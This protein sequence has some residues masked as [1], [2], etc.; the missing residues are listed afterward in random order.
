MFERVK[1]FL[2]AL[3]LLLALFFLFASSH[4]VLWRGNPLSSLALEVV[5]PIERLLAVAAFRVE[6]LWR[7]Y[8]YLVNLRQENEALH[9]LLDRQERKIIELVEFKVAHD[10]LTSLLGLQEAYPHLI[11]KPAHVLARDPVPWARSVIISLGALDGVLIDQ[12]VIQNRGVVGRVIETAPH[13]ARVLLATDFTSSIDAF[14]QR[15]RAV[16]LLRGGGSGP[17]LLKYV[18]KDEDVCSGDQI[19]TSGLDGF[20]PRGLALGTVSWV[21]RQSV[22]MFME[23]EAYPQVTF[24]RLEEVMV[25]INLG[26]PIDWLTLAPRFRSL[27]EDARIW[28][29]PPPIQP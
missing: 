23:V 28:D 10:R 9:E 20:F 24:D 13:Y 4:D 1:W 17:L 21:N 12:A 26:P 3:T 14:V 16:G 22:G 11:M 29:V 5:G 18:R 8:L 19:I 15:S 2:P 27:L 25:L 7:N 6:T